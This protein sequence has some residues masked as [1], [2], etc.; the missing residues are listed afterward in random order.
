MADTDVTIAQLR[1]ELG[2]VKTA[3]RAKDFVTARIELTCASATRAG[4]NAK[5]SDAGGMSELAGMG[6]E[7][8]ALATQ[9]NQLDNLANPQRTSFTTG[10][11]P[12]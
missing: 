3:L 8:N 4:L 12:T 11:M 2:R 1:V 5:I 6:N 10:R 7:L 9:L